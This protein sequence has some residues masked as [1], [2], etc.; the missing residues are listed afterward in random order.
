M[1]PSAIAG[2]VL[3]GLGLL[4]LIAGDEVGPSSFFYYFWPVMFV[5]PVGIFFHWLY[6]KA[7]QRRGSG[8][9]IPG[10]ILLTVSAV[11]QISML[12][13]SWKYMW[14]GFILAPA[15]GLL[16]FYWF[17]NR[18]RWLL[19]PIVLLS[20]LSVLFFFI[21]SVGYL[22]QSISGAQPF[23]AVILL[24]SGASLLLINKKKQQHRSFF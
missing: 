2:V 11:C 8:V 18:N 15:I 3:L 16:E 12:F 1:K 10:G 6:F 22:L 5:M 9:L 19:I 4:L 13:D 14:P 7:L 20:S 21:F 24:V 23:I 17:G